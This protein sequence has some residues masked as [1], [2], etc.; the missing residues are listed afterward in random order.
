MGIQPD[1][2]IYK[3]RRNMSMKIDNYGKIIVNAPKQIC[4]NDLSKF[5]IT[6]QDWI[7]KKQEE[8]KNKL[9]KIHQLDYN[10]KYKIKYKISA[11]KVFKD[12]VEYFATKYGFKYNKIKLSSA[13]TRW[14]S[15]SNN[16]N[17]NLNWKL[18]FAPD[19]VIDYV[20]IHELM[21][22]KHFNHSKKYWSELS[23]LVSDYKNSK[24]W[25]KENEYLLML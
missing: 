1:K 4:Q 12:R 23:K 18:I 25:L 2:I 19:D 9:N 14:G 5:I 22:L 16:K 3:K 17:I 10:P 15:C 24:K 20:I 8:F 11:K 21:H 13:K 6:N 7:I